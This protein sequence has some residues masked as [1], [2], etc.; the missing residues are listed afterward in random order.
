MTNE[1][2]IDHIAWHQGI[3]WASVHGNG[4]LD[5]RCA[6]ASK[7]FWMAP[8]YFALADL[9]RLHPQEFAGLV[10]KR[11]QQTCERYNCADWMRE[12]PEASSKLDIKATLRA[13][14]AQLE[15]LEGEHGKPA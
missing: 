6:L 7:L 12:K 13:Y 3:A 5:D 1:E 15:A 8:W 2:F 14:L 9:A 11:K 4:L 10:E